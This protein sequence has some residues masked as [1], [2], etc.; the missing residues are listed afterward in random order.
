MA[1]PLPQSVLGLEPEAQARLFERP[2]ARTCCPPAD[3]GEEQPT[4]QR[5][6]L[7]GSISFGGSVSVGGSLS[8]SGLGTA[9]AGAVGAVFGPAPLGVL[10]DR[11][12]QLGP[13]KVLK[14]ELLSGLRAELTD[15][16]DAELAAA[17]RSAQGCPYLQRWLAHY[18]GQSA[19][20]VERA[21][22]LYARP[23]GRTAEALRDAVLSRARRAVQEWVRTG[24]A[25]TGAPG[26]SLQFKR[27]SASP[28]HAADPAAV[29]TRL[30]PGEPLPGGVRSRM[31]G[32]FGS[33]FS[34]VR[35]HRDGVAAGLARD[36][37]ARAFTVGSH[38]AF[39]A[40]EYRPGSL[41]GDLL[42]AHELAHTQQQ[43]AG[44][45]RQGSDLGR[46]DPALE[47]QA[48]LAA[49]GA[50]ARSHGLPAVLPS[51]RTS[52][53]LR[54]Q[55]C[56]STPA[57]T[58]TALPSTVP[59]PGSTDFLVTGKH[60]GASGDPLGLYYERNAT[61]PDSVEA[62]KV[63]AIKSPTATDAVELRAFRS[64]DEAAS[65]AQDRGDAVRALFV[66]PPAHGTTPTVTALPDGAVG[67]PDYRRVRKVEMVVGTAAPTT[68]DCQARDPI[69]NDLVNP[70]HDTCPNR[71][72]TTETE[73]QAAH[74]HAKTLL[75]SAITGLSPANRGSGRT[76][77]LLQR[78]F[79]SQADSTADTVKQ[80]L[81]TVRTHLLAAKTNNRI[82][83]G[84]MCDPACAS[85]TI[86]HNNGVDYVAST[87]WYTV[88]VPTFKGSHLHDQA[89]NVI[90]EIAHGTPGLGG[91]ATR[92]TRDLAYRHERI[93]THLQTSEA[94]RNSDS[95]ALFAV[96]MTH[97]SPQGISTPSSDFYEDFTDTAEEAAAQRAIAHLEKRV[98]AGKWAASNLYRLYN[99]QREAAAAGR[100]V[101]P[102]GG[103]LALFNLTPTYFPV[104]APPG[105][106]TM[107]DQQRMAAILDAF[108]RWR[109][110]KQDMTIRR[111]RTGNVTWS[112][113]LGL[114]LE[115][116]P[117]FFRATPADQIS[118]LLE[119]LIRWEGRVP[120]SF[121]P[122]HVHWAAEAQRLAMA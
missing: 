93:I 54:L 95:Y 63:T 5:F 114:N 94:L 22:Q 88:C 70:P 39:G 44:L 69:T 59:T 96:H 6:A 91:S 71:D 75:D 115:L 34:G 106:A 97:A 49:A 100:T 4:I 112:S 28:S 17:G 67:R 14:S 51:A 79:A 102:S 89:R 26:M 122:A 82:R 43:G 117:E 18:E 108:S 9:L 1:Q 62:A 85:G 48:D 36:L 10:V 7:G 76:P 74:A 52:G 101:D 56:S 99:L 8:T 23:S 42:L 29:Q 38:V 98:Q 12:D 77:A 109:A 121:V 41:P 45:A 86:A 47:A 27:E 46:D 50:V 31:E 53:G 80:N 72:A 11:S 103:L 16:C 64:E 2:G 20:H 111:A 13:G 73:F 30:G 83:C 32:A 84:N 119:A 61:T 107:V 55:R 87:A 116:G 60:P 37:S 68:V 90:H 21:I 3:P 65:K 33:S 81:E 40:G 19:A 113:A 66:A 58:P 78:F 92:G 24:R 110:V 120:A 118:L 104:S 25:P 35:V 15:V 105:M 57:P